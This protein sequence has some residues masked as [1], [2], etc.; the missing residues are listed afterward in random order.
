MKTD[1]PESKIGGFAK[2]GTH[3]NWL[4]AKA[5]GV[6]QQLQKGFWIK[7]IALQQSPHKR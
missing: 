6:P 1:R 4:A 5:R 3:A 2:Q 7:V